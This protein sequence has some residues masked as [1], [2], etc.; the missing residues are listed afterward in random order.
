MQER[1]LST[2]A[3]GPAEAVDL[4]WNAA[5]S[6]FLYELARVL[7]SSPDHASLIRSIADGVCALLACEVALV[8]LNQAGRPV[9]QGWPELTRVP[10]LPQRLP[11]LEL[12]CVA[13]ALHHAEPQQEVLGRLAAAGNEDA[14]A[15]LPG[16]SALCVPVFSRGRLIGTLTAVS[17]GVRVFSRHEIERLVRVAGLSA[18]C[19]HSAWLAEE[20]QR[21]LANLETLLRLDEALNAAVTPE[22]IA[23]AAC[24]ALRRLFPASSGVLALFNQETTGP[25]GAGQATLH[26]WGDGRGADCLREG[27]RASRDVQA[28]TVQ[29]SACWSLR[30]GMRVNVSDAMR[31]ICCPLLPATELWQAYVCVPLF[32]PATAGPFQTGVVSVKFP[33]PTSLPA[34]ERDLIYYVAERTAMALAHL[35]LL[36]ESRAQGRAEGA[37]RA[38]RAVAHEFGQP[39]SLLAGYAELLAAHQRELPQD[40]QEAIH[41]ISG[42]VERLAGLIQQF[43]QVVGYAERSPGPG[44]EMLDLQRAQRPLRQ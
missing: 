31:D 12:A 36:A 35:R 39:L 8:H 13:P 44:L 41:S 33:A 30:R 25:P 28:E 26:T 32:A 19:L 2:S 43:R 27:L 3:A 18:F 24:A 21:H 40:V 16:L 38:A 9:L 37:V 14:T 4:D 42:A 20:Q 23:Q 15:C 29:A 11:E 5:E 6:Y 17:A 10:S 34:A 1:D 22:E 7:G